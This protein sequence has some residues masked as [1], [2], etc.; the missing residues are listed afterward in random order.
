MLSITAYQA[1]SC[2]GLIHL[3]LTLISP[4]RTEIYEQ[5]DSGHFLYAKQRIEIK[6]SF[7]ANLTSALTLK[8][9]QGPLL[10][11]WLNLWVFRVSGLA[12]VQKSPA[13]RLQGAWVLST[14]LGTL[15]SPWEGMRH[16]EYHCGKRYWKEHGIIWSQVGT[17]LYS[18]HQSLLTNT[19]DHSRNLPVLQFPISKIHL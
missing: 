12:L 8:N 11:R 2:V 6:W 18:T 5:V 3:L 13:N 19:L 4:W 16:S 15:H 17:G 14:S 9:L 1:R 10:C 7:P